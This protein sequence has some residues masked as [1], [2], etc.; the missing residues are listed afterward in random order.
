MASSKTSQYIQLESDPLIHVSISYW[1][2]HVK[3]VKH[4][5]D[6]TMSN[7]AMSHFVIKLKASNFKHA[8]NSGMQ[9]RRLFIIKIIKF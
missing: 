3:Y 1:K 8:L 4:F 2:S 5:F 7:P 6:A 9:I